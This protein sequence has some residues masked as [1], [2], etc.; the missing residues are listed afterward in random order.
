M[1]DS[2]NKPFL[3][4]CSASATKYANIMHIGA[5]VAGEKDSSTNNGKCRDVEE[6]DGKASGSVAGSDI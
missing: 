3:I 5:Q 4:I 6:G 2:F 1:R